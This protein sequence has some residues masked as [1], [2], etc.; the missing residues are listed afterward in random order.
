M[1]DTNTIKKTLQK[2]HAASESVKAAVAAVSEL[3]EAA[4][5]EDEAEERDLA[6]A[7]DPGDIVEEIKWLE[8]DLSALLI[9]R[10]AAA[11]IL[12]VEELGLDKERNPEEDQSHFHLS[13]VSKEMERAVGKEGER[14]FVFRVS[15]AGEV[16]M[17]DEG[18]KQTSILIVDD[19]AV[20]RRVDHPVSSDIDRGPDIIA[21]FSSPEAAK[22]WCHG[23]FRE[24]GIEIPMR[25]TL[26][27]KDG[28]NI[29]PDHESE[30][31]W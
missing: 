7:L 21:A 23:F 17:Y 13:P 4:S 1:L 31:F 6:G 10:T 18:A 19:S 16:V 29:S 5:D 12:I 8:Q 22:A 24:E 20:W 27:S 9:E 28:I 14:R 15:P 3:T 26:A 25:G 11:Y 30:L 2:V